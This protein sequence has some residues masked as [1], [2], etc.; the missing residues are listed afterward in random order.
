MRIRTDLT[1]RIFFR[2]LSKFPE[3]RQKTENTKHLSFEFR[4]KLW[5]ICITTCLEYQTT[6]CISVQSS[7]C[8]GPRLPRVFASEN[9]E[10][11]LQIHPTRV[12]SHSASTKV[13]CGPLFFA[14]PMWKWM[15]SADIRCWPAE[16]FHIC[17]PFDRQVTTGR[18]GNSAIHTVDG[19]FMSSNSEGGACWP[20]FGVHECKVSGVL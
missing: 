5:W 8:S 15:Q 13:E 7:D 20:G 16:K 19:I 3:N 17:C 11:N 2:T 9:G 12:P 18:W 14:S 6:P 10:Q 1:S 4:L